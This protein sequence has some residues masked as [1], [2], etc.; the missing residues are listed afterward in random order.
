MSWLVE[1]SRPLSA[2]AAVGLKLKRGNLNP[3]LSGKAGKAQHRADSR[4]GR[5]DELQNSSHR[6]DKEIVDRRHESVRSL[7]PRKKQS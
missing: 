7:V 6:K 2:K 4:Q 3:D 1:E 5:N